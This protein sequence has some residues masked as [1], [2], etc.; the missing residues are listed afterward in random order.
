MEG[1]PPRDLLFE[2]STPLGF[3]VRATRAHWAVISA[4]KHPVMAGQDEKVREVLRNPDEIRVSQTDAMVYLFY[5]LERPARWICAV[6]KR[7]NGEGF[8][9]T[10]YPT[11]AIKEGRHLWPR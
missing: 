2:I 9:I 4:L 6:A 7:L 11:D 3:S 5:K 1:T 10:A 8:L